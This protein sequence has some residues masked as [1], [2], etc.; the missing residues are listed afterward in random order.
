[1]FW[2]V[3]G[4]LLTGFLLYSSIRH[5]QRSRCAVQRDG[6]WKLLVSRSNEDGL[7]VD[8]PDCSS[9]SVRG[10]L[11]IFQLRELYPDGLG[12]VRL[13]STGNLRELAFLPK[14]GSWSS[15]VG[16]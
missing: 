12:S 15:P 1:M 3:K 4:W 6:E 2:A 5:H 9:C 16:P 14:G 8:L 11:G 7:A 13:F 10:R